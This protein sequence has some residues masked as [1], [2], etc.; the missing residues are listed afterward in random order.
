MSALSDRFKAAWDQWGLEGSDITPEV[1]FHPTRRWRWDFAF[2]SQMVAVEINGIGYGHCSPK[3]MS[4]D[5]EK[6]RAGILLGW[7]VVP[8]CSP[9]LGSKQKLQD[10]V[11]F[12]VK[13][14][15][16]KTEERDGLQI[17]F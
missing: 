9:C 17:R 5:A 4:R 7:T 12:V 10:A 6:M 14:L 15:V 11:E 1:R 3:G 13:I 16:K 2:P 8:F